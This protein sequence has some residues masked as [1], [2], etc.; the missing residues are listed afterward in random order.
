MKNLKK[1]AS[2]GLYK[3]VRSG[4]GSYIIE[5]AMPLNINVKDK[6]LKDGGKFQYG[7]VVSDATSDS[8][9]DY[10]YALSLEGI[11]EEG[12]TLKDLIFI[13]DHIEYSQGK[14][15]IVLSDTVPDTSLLSQNEES[16]G[17]SDIGT[18]N[19][20][21]AEINPSNGQPAGSSGNGSS[22]GSG[23]ART[24]DDKYKRKCSNF[25]YKYSLCS[26]FSHF[27]I[28]CSNYKKKEI[29]FLI[30]KKSKPSSI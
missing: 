6:I 22:A 4:D 20:G 23:N 27:T 29:N 12:L 21:G 10:D 14:Y 25:R 1:N 15:S 28:S 24:G 2:D 11:F 3:T 7:L 30:F 13:Q 16:G 19:N 5:F 18:G 9:Y 17:G 8:G 26:S